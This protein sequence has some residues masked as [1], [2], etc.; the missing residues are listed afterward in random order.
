MF[1][2]VNRTPQYAGGLFTPENALRQVIEIANVHKRKLGALASI[3]LGMTCQLSPA[4][5][6]RYSGQVSE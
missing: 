4:A 6:Q 2:L 3:P 1:T 5:Q